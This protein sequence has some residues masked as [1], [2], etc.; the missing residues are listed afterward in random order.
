MHRPCIFSISRQ[1]ADS[2]SA[3]WS[4]T[5]LLGLHTSV[6]VL[7]D[8]LVCWLPSALSISYTA[9]GSSSNSDV[10]KKKYGDRVKEKIPFQPGETQF[11]ANYQ[12]AVTTVVNEMDDEERKNAEELVDSWNKDGPPGAYQL[13]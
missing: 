5:T 4:I 13:K 10:I 12:R 6:T 11:V 9:S 1:G 3:P 2:G 8:G 7:L